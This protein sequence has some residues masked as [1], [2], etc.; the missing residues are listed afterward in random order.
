MVV[1]VVVAFK[2]VLSD[3]V[4]VVVPPS[5]VLSSSIGDAAALGIKELETKNWCCKK[6]QRYHAFKANHEIRDLTESIVIE[7]HLRGSI[8]RA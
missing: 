7:D 5:V 6:Q 1:V 8:I 4:V 2:D 3:I